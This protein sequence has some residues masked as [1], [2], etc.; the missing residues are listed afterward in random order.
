MNAHPQAINEDTTAPSLY[1]ERILKAPQ[2]RVFEAFADPEQM[3]KWFGPDGCTCRRNIMD[4]RKGGE[5]SLTV[6]H[7]DGSESTVSGQYS[8]IT[9]YQ[10][11]EFTWGWLQDDGTRGTETVV[12]IDF[13]VE[14][15]TTKL[16]LNQGVFGAAEFRDK[17]LSGWSACFDGL[18]IH[19]KG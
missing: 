4:V 9:P 15:D 6:V 18:E 7:P 2:Q 1:I 14:G 8:T 10:F 16:V 11:L 12:K 3:Y 13:L 19:L 5:Y 17:H